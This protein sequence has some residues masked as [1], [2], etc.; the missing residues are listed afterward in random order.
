MDSP[1]PW[2]SQDTTG[3]PEFGDG[4]TAR[5]ASMGVEVTLAWRAATSALL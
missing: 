2:R 3:A 4:F 1:A 5:D